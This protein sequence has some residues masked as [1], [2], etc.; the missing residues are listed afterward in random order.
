MNTVVTIPLDGEKNEEIA[1]LVADKQPGDTL[2]G[3][4]TIKANDGKTLILRTKEITDKKDDLPDYEEREDDE[5]DEEND[6]EEEED[7]NGSS[8]SETDEA[9]RL[10]SPGGYMGP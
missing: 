4:F 8:T 10:A 7:G 2:Y 5:S 1:A 6:T 9:I 3:C